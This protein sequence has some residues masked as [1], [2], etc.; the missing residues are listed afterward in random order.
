VP[1]VLPFAGLRY[2]APPGEL[3]ALLSPPY[4]VIDAD[5]QAQL[6]ARSTGNASYIELPSDAPG[7]PG[8]RYQ[9]AAERLAAWRQQR[10][11]LPDPRPAYYFSETEFVYAGQ[12]L[13]RR[14]VLAALG[15]EPW[16]SGA[17]L[18]HEHTMSAPKADRLELLRST[19][20]N[21]SPIWVLHRDRLPAL[22]QAWTTAAANPPTVEFA[23]RA[24]RHRLWVVDDPATTRAIAE[25]FEHAGPLYI[26]DGH[27]RY[28]TSLAFR[29]EADASVPGS[30]ATL[31][32]VTWADDPG[33]LALPTHRLL[34]TV[35]PSF[36]LEA[37]RRRWA[38]LF[39]VEMHPVADDQ[40]SALTQLLAESGRAAPSF[41]VFGLGDPRQFG[42]L[43]LRNR[44]LPVGA[45][46]P[47]HSAAWRSLDVSLLHALLVDPL[48]AQT[49]RPRE[50]VLGY[51]RYAEQAL[52]AVRDGQA[53]V[54]F[55]LNATPVEGVLAV[56]DAHDRMPEKSTYFFPKPP[57]GVVMRD[58]DLP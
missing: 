52:A 37:A 54:A 39:S 13:R 11:L 1:T 40:P 45:L 46:P 20:L 28:E 12:T 26:A 58:L 36:T 9:L 47:D 10:V 34:H 32:A 17:V 4:D 30:R 33:L 38:D 51:T 35:D 22:D 56:A 3:E 5:E 6:Q 7:R 8:S 48:V 31:A 25:A 44:S 42:I 29:A 27:H 14:D 24:E 23:W 50:Q 53:A 2:A 43:R 19:H 49:N 16:S 55:L 15:V 18:P 21:V 57:A 41:G